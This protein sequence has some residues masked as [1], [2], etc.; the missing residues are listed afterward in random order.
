MMANFLGMVGGG[1]G[2]L[3]S[4]PR[5]VRLVLSLDIDG[6][7]INRELVTQKF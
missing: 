1:L 6:I 7:A 3:V 2:C 4:L 5:S